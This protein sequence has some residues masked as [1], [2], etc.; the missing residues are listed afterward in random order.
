MQA[1]ACHPMRDRVPSE[2]EIKQL[3]AVDHPLLF[4]GQ[5][6]GRL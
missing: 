5:G 4:G 6:P 2:A 3:I 1:T